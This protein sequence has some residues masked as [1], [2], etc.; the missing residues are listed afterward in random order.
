MDS[1]FAFSINPHVL[2]IIIS[3]SLALL[4]ISNFLLTELSN[5]SESILFLSHPRQVLI[6]KEELSEL[7]N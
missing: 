4:V 1:C 2:I 3:D 6:T 5:I 7:N